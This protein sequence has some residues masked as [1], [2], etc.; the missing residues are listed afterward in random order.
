MRK[1]AIRI[2]LESR[3]YLE[4]QLHL[5]RGGHHSS[6]RIIDHIIKES[7]KPYN[8]NG[9]V[10]MDGDLGG[11][12]GDP[13]NSYEEGRW[14]S[15]TIEDMKRMLDEQGLPYFDEEPIDVIDVW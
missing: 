2:P 14:T 10:I 4:D 11:A 6:E 15:W 1:R 5:Q 3:L 12:I 13:L 9:F 7:Q 8:Q